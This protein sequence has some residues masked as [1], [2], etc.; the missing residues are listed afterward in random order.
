MIIIDSALRKRAEQGKPIRVGMIGAGFMGRGVALNIL[1][2]VSGM[3]IVAISNRN[4]AG[5]ERAYREAG[6]DDVSR[7]STVSALEDNI[8]RGKRAVTDDALIL[9]Q[10]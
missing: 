1:N 5:A 10:A 2:N 3:D 8:H 9:C 7:V 6:V 4:I